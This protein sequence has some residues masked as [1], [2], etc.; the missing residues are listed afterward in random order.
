MFSEGEIKSPC[1]TTQYHEIN[2]KFILSSNVTVFGHLKEIPISSNSGHIGWIE[3]WSYTI[4][5]G[6]HP[7]IIPDRLCL[8][9]H[10]GFTGED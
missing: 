9:W 2:F 5:K 10:C 7:M 3:R 8:L 4:L 6:G 1:S